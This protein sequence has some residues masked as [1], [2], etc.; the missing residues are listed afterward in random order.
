MNNK[1][2]ELEEERKKII[3]EQKKANK[4]GIPVLVLSVVPFVLAAMFEELSFIFLIL[5][6]VLLIT[7][8]IIIGT[9]QK[10]VGPFKAS[11]KK[12]IIETLLKENYENVNYD[13][14]GHIPLQTFLQTG[15]TKSPDRWKAEDLITGEKSGVKFSVSEFHLE[16]RQVRRD[17]KG[18]TYVTYET[19][20]RGRFFI[21]EYKRD[22]K[23]E[24]RINE[25]GLIN[26]NFAPKGFK[27]IETES[28]AFNKKFN[29]QSTS[30]QHA[31]Y[32]ITPIMLEEIQRIES[33]FKGHLGL[34][35]RGNKL[36]M[37]IN[38]NKNTLEPNIKVPLVGESLDYYL[39]DILIMDE[40]IHAFDLSHDRFM[41]THE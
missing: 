25:K 40:I 23:D 3:E 38:D 24:L 28:I 26:L 4:K 29:V 8:F 41:E 22:F 35:F 2:I 27:K 21:F 39:Y 9:G 30:E 11:F 16:D 1:L 17:S 32:L 31:F 36:Y 19:Y 10:R 15:L 37:A 13:P 18:N 7:G 5:A 12:N 6:I 14:K 20:F 33:L 34:L